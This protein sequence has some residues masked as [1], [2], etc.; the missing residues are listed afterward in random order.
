L[1]V[2]VGQYEY[3]RAA[4]SS[5]NLS[6]GQFNRHA[7]IPEPVEVAPH[8]GHPAAPLVCD[9]FDND[10]PRQGRAYRAGKFRPKARASS[11]HPLC[12]RVARAAYVLAGEPTANQIGRRRGQFANVPEQMRIRPMS[13]QYLAARRIGLALPDRLGV[14][15]LGAKTAFEP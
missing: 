1:L 9:I 7:G 4:V 8:D 13:P 5:S 15:A 6:G 11:R 2:G 10:P 3:A 12:A 14:D